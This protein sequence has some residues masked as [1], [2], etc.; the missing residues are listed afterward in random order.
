VVIP[1]LGGFIANYTPAT[2]LPLKNNFAPPSKEILFNSNLCNNDG[3]LA[4]YIA[5]SEEITYEQA[6]IRIEQ[7]IQLLFQDLQ[8]GIVVILDNA[9]TLRLNGEKN[10]F[11]TPNNTQNFLEESFGLPTFSTPTIKR[12][13]KRPIISNRKQLNLSKAL[14]RIAAILIP[15]IALALWMFFNW[16][17]PYGIG[18]NLSSVFPSFHL[19]TSPHSIIENQAS[20]KINF[21]KLTDNALEINI[22]PTPTRFSGVD[23]EI[24]M[25]IG[26][27]K[28]FKQPFA[29]A[30][31]GTN[32]K[33]DFMG[34]K[35]GSIELPDG[36]RLGV[37]HIKAQYII[38]EGAFKIKENAEK[39]I[40][41]LHEMEINA[42][43]E[44]QNKNGLYLVST[45]SC[46]N[47]PS[48]IEKLR[49]LKAKG[50]QSAWILKK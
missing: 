2:I 26:I 41:E 9:G 49:E 25:A 47:N 21:P 6:L 5:C 34:I 42:T 3:L 32:N 1:G 4:N 28:G 37:A 45:A 38:I 29:Q 19:T 33:S 30:L 43:I 13:E 18:T 11:F 36:Y 14:G 48:A 8:S 35:K 7:E 46:N 27:S 40:K 10:I 22:S 15:L 24:E 12:K 20:T 44:G 31:T 16:N 50:I 39:R 23:P 17:Q